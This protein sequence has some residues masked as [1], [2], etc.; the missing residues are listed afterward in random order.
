M[1]RV[2]ADHNLEAPLQG[3]AAY[4]NY[5]S[6][7]QSEPP[8]ATPRDS[9]P[10]N[11]VPVE[12][13][14]SENAKGVQTSPAAPS[15]ETYTDTATIRRW[16]EDARRRVEEW[17]KQSP[18]FSSSSSVSPSRSAADSSPEAICSSTVVN[19]VHGGDCHII[20]YKAGW[21]EGDLINTRTGPGQDYSVANKIAIGEKGLVMEFRTT[22]NRGTPWV[23]VFRWNDERKDSPTFIGWANRNFLQ[24]D[25]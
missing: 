6:G 20:K 8:D 17:G 3:S 18:T 19:R 10:D 1:A 7:E 23:R 14:N 16:V 2:S 5:I 21:K 13:L 12:P 25:R 15:S 9:N 24:F 11:P 22:S 4:P